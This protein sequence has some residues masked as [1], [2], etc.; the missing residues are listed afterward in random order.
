MSVCYRLSVNTFF[1]CQSRCAVLPVVLPALLNVLTVCPCSQRTANEQPTSGSSNFPFLR[2]SHKTPGV[3]QDAGVS[4]ATYH[5]QLCL[6]SST[7]ILFCFTP[8][9]KLIL[10]ACTKL[11]CGLKRNPRETFFHISLLLMEGD[12]L[13]A[14]LRFPE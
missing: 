6:S 4:A 14:V 12:A 3:N 10:H 5:C 2:L 1:R 7:S 9:I 8:L 11:L 13:P